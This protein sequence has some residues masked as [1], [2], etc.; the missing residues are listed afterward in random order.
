[1]IRI[2]RLI[3]WLVT[4]V[5][6][7]FL[8]WFEVLSQSTNS[9][10]ERHAMVHWEDSQFIMF[11]SAT[12]EKANTFK[13]LLYRKKN[14]YSIQTDGTTSDIL[15]KWEQ[16][17]KSELKS[18][19]TRTK[20]YVID[21]TGNVI[22]SLKQD[23]SRLIIPVRYFVTDSFAQNATEFMTARVS[24]LDSDNT[25]SLSKILN[26]TQERK[27]GFEV[28]RNNEKLR[29]KTDSTI[30]SNGA[31]LFNVHF[32]LGQYYLTG[33]SPSNSGR[34]DIDHSA[35][36]YRLNLSYGISPRL[37]IIGGLTLSA[38]PP[39]QEAMSVQ[40]SEQANAVTFSNEIDFQFILSPGIGIKYYLKRE[41]YRLFTTASFQRNYLRLT[42]F[43]TSRRQNDIPRQRTSIDNFTSNAFNLGFGLE[44]S[45]GTRLSFSIQTEYS[46]ASDYD[47]Q[48]LDL[49][50]FSYVN[51][52]LGMKYT[53]GQP[54][55][56]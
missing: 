51:V 24:I 31:G 49:R 6:A 16:V 33:K 29:Q 47:D 44:T 9:E 4:L 48:N 32:H 13:E 18:Q 7:L 27:W 21:F 12:S 39:D 15:Y 2:E 28:E 38:N 30:K 36:M 43:T 26:E 5:I 42:H 10:I 14:G 56:R 45:L 19:N 23:H 1:M 55:M 34:Y 40:A 22:P 37:E 11:Y 3:S 54:K 46:Q 53:F 52:L 35:S 50:A 25:K 41:G 8:N 20:Y 17:G